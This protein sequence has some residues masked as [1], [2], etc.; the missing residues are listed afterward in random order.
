M[1][2]R[3][4]NIFVHIYHTHIIYI[5]IHMCAYMEYYMRNMPLQRN[6]ENEKKILA[7][8][9]SHSEIII[10][11]NCACEIHFEHIQCITFIFYWFQ[12]KF[13]CA[14]QH[15]ISISNTQK[16]KWFLRNQI[17]DDSLFCRLYC[18]TSMHFP[19]ALIFLAHYFF[20][21]FTFV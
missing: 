11:R 20:F 5:Y 17:S 13:G 9:V 21:N 15:Y 16:M 4:K 8:A 2:Y 7:R 18:S 12:I 3:K 10:Q 19:T 6:W 1:Y 14:A